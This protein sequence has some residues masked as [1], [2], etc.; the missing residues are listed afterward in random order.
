MATQ[1]QPRPGDESRS[2]VPGTGE[3]ACRACQG[4][5][6]VNGKT[7]PDCDGTGKVVEGIGGG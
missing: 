7:C 6:K 5:G 3:N 2:G 1:P 4:S